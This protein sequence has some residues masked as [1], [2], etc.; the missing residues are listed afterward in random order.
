MTKADAKITA[1]RTMQNNV[2]KADLVLI[3]NLFVFFV[4]SDSALIL[5]ELFTRNSFYEPVAS[6][7]GKTAFNF[8]ALFVSVLVFILSV[9]VL[10]AMRFGREFWFWQRSNFEFAPFTLIFTGFGALLK[11][12]L[13]WLKLKIFSLCWYLAFLS[14]A[15]L[16][17]GFIYYLSLNS[18]SLVVFYALLS[19]AVLL[20][21][22][23]TLFGFVVVQR[24]A[25][26]YYALFDNSDLT[27]KQAINESKRIMSG[28]EIKTAMLKLSFWGWFITCLL[29]APSF[30]V[31]PYYKLSCA[32]FLRHLYFSE[33]KIHWHSLKIRI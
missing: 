19:V 33:G 2:A 4:F 14:P 5:S 8:T 30:Y 17:G 15:L 18:L 23:G 26:S 11:N 29:I 7:M 28:N 24:Y 9:I 12:S 25:V 1:K 13:L 3:L 10:A 16:I 32:V 27:T 31:L 6:F 20:G 22:I 21:I